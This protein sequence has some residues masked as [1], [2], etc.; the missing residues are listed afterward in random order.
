M[1]DC[2]CRRSSS[3]GPAWAFSRGTGALRPD[4]VGSGDRDP[5][6]GGRAVRGGT[7]WHVA[8]RPAVGGRSGV[9]SQRRLARVVPDPDRERRPPGRVGIRWGIGVLARLAGM[10][11]G[12]VGRNAAHDR[13]DPMPEI[14]ATSEVEAP[15]GGSGQHRRRCRPGPDPRHH[16][17]GAGVHGGPHRPG[18]AGAVAE[19]GGPAGRLRPRADPGAGRGTGRVRRGGGPGGGGRGQRPGPGR[20]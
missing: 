20:R 2:G 4:T 9:G 16:P 7:G 1:S 5:P 13:G 3:F 8:V 18:G 19:P 6:R 17:G 14:D 11:T 12:D 15:R 10:A